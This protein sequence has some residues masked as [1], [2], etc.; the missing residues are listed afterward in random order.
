[1]ADRFTITDSNS[2]YRIV[3]H[4]TKCNIIFL[5]HDSFAYK[6]TMERKFFRVRKFLIEKYSKKV[7]HA[8]MHVIS[9][10]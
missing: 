9:T 3:F 7:M 8:I 4:N 2:P 6:D 5:E 10:T 1:M